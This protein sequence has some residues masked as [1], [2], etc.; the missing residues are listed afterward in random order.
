MRQNTNPDIMILKKY[1]RKVCLVI[2]FFFLFSS[3]RYAYLDPG[4]GS[5]ILQ[6]II[7]FIA[8]AIAFISIYWAKKIFSKFKKK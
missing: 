4:T 1:K 2:A 5:I 6:A 7:A 3:E 8:G